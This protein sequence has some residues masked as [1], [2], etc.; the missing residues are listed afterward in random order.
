MIMKKVFLSFADEDAQKVEKLISLLRSPNYELDFYEGSLDLDFDAEGA[1]AVRKAIGEKI[2]KCNIAVCLIGENTHKS[3][4]VD[5]QLRKNRNKGNKIIAMALK[6]VQYAILP[7]V[8]KEEFLT[9]YPWDP[10]KLKTLITDDA[11]K[12]FNNSS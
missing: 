11:R 6:G 3:R 5:S 7:D 4:W 1:E 2:V 12:L 8:V 9:F 10:Q